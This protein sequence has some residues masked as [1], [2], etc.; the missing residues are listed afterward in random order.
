MM[1]EISA[2]T[3]FDRYQIKMTTI[4]LDFWLASAGMK[5]IFKNEIDTA[6]DLC[7]LYWIN[8]EYA[9]YSTRK[10]RYGNGVCNIREHKNITRTLRATV[11]H[12]CL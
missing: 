7:R 5:L 8:P 10:Q 12:K 2:L 9:L 6:S 4:S 3:L 1:N 11:R